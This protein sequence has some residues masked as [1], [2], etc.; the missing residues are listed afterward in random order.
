MRIAVVSDTHGQLRADIAEELKTY[1][2]LMHAGDFDDEYTYK[3]LS[4]GIGAFLGVKGNCDWFAYGPA[5]P[6][7]RKVE[8]NGAVVFMTH[9]P[10]DVGRY[11]N[12]EADIVIHGH[13]HERREEYRNGVL[14]LNPGSLSQPR[15]GRPGYCIL[16]IHDGSYSVEWRDLNGKKPEAT[17]VQ[18][19]AEMIKKIMKYTDRGMTIGLI[20]DKL[21]L[22]Y[23]TVEKAVRMYLTHPGVGVEGIIERMGK[24]R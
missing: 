1:D 6:L 10:G 15:D 23:E 16:D 24:P 3:K 5:L 17:A 8:L 20:S 14:Y 2:L 11:L 4:G 18:P 9:R 13:T 12:G 7:S 22:P 21:K 19:D